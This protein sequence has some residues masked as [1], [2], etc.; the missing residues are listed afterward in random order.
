MTNEPLYAELSVEAHD[1]LLV[2][3]NEA[4]WRTV[5]IEE[6]TEEARSVSDPGLAAKRLQDLAHSYGS[7][8]ELSIMV[9]RFHVIYYII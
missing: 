8:D 4:F 6:A 2:V 7:E 9:L 1:E 5:T 3:A